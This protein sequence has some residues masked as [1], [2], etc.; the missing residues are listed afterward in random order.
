MKNN[1]GKIIGILAVVCF[2]ALWGLWSQLTGRVDFKEYHVKQAAISGEMSVISEPGIYARLFGSV[3]PYTRA[4][5]FYFSQED[6]DGG[7]SAESQ[8]LKATFMGNSTADVSGICKF[9]LP[10]GKEHQL[11]LHRLYGSNQAI[12][13]QLIRN[14]IAGALKQT[15]P[16]FRPEEAFITKRA[17]F[18]NLVRRQLEEGLFA[19]STEIVERQ[20]IEEESI[21]A[22]GKPLPQKIKVIRESVTSLKV[23][24]GKPVIERP[25]V[26]TQNG[27]IITDFVIKDFDFDDVTDANIKKKKEAEQIQVVARANAEKA[28][29]DAITAK[30]EGEARIAKARADE[31]V[32]KIKEVTK[33]E[34]ARDVA[35][36]DAEKAIEVAKKIKAEGDAKAFAAKKLVEAGLTPLKRAQIEKETMIGMAEA[37]AK[38]PVPVMVVGSEGG[39]GGIDPLAPLGYKAMVEMVNELKTQKKQ[40][41]Q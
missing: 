24:N 8:A 33:A 10:T 38:R 41:S 35:R 1:K 20:E 26:L 14:A 25:S 22:N 34:K 19:T 37:W 13:M 29:Q 12:E 32:E 6:L 11:A 28:K 16:M 2:V 9:M 3:Q 17:Q 27:I 23:V 7:K 40:L 30:M 36:L 21:D 5:M 39:K 31:Q 15:G 18:T 4:G